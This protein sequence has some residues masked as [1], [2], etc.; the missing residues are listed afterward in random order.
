MTE[1][2]L[3]VPSPKMPARG[4]RWA[5]AGV[6]S[7]IPGVG[8]GCGGV[9][10]KLDRAD[11]TYCCI[12]AAESSGVVEVQIPT[13]DGRS[14]R[15][16]DGAA[17]VDLVGD[18]RIELGESV[19]RATATLAVRALIRRKVSDGCDLLRRLDSAPGGRVQ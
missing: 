19:D 4:T 11:I 3:H 16:A 6:G 9:V 18:V 13:S 7:N 10:V 2:T 17:K 15:D 1:L 14:V 8:R 5:I 12:R